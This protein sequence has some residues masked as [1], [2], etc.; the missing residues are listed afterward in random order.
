MFER[1]LC[2]PSIASVGCVAAY[3]GHDA[4]IHTLHRG[5]GLLGGQ[6]HPD[7]SGWAREGR[8][9]AELAWT[10]SASLG[11]LYMGYTECKRLMLFV[12]WASA[13]FLIE[14]KDKSYC[15]RSYAW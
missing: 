12:W 2:T 8:V 15:H 14:T 10:L 4:P 5:C 9:F 13:T 7:P 3:R 1:V 6:W 11:V